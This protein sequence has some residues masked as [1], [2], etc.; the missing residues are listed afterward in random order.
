MKRKAA[1]FYVTALMG[2]FAGLALVVSAYGERSTGVL[3]LALAWVALAGIAQYFW[4]RCP[5]CHRSALQRP[6]GDATPFVGDACRYCGR[7]Y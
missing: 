3:V 7:A 2:L 6:S 5:H 4:L 1:L